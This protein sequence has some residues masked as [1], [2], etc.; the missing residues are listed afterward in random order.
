MY[1]DNK[2]WLLKLWCGSSFGISTHWCNTTNNESLI[3]PFSF[4]QTLNNA[5]LN[6]Q[7]CIEC[8]R[9]QLLRRLN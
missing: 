8:R 1:G 9:V 7:T 2:L 3:T 6:G 5:M 4:L